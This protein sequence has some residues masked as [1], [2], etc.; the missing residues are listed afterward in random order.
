MKMNEEREKWSDTSNDVIVHSGTWMNIGYIGVKHEDGSVSIH[1]EPIERKFIRD[2][3]EKSG[4]YSLSKYVDNE[5][6]DQLAKEQLSEATDMTWYE[7]EEEWEYGRQQEQQYRANR[8]WKHYMLAKEGIEMTDS[9]KD[10]G[11]Y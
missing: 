6:I 4:V 10:A 8:A 1:Y 2:Y 7:L 9:F 3:V 11:V 5:S